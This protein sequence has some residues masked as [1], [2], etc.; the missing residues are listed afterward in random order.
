M[1]R[2][3]RLFA[4][5][6]ILTIILSRTSLMMLMSFRFFTASLSVGKSGRARGSL[7]QQ[8]L[9]RRGQNRGH[10]CTYWRGCHPRHLYN[11]HI[12]PNKDFH[13]HSKYIPEMYIWILMDYTR[14]IWMIGRTF[15]PPWGAPAVRGTPGQ[16][17]DWRGLTPRCCSSVTLE[18]TAA[19]R[20]T[21]RETWD[22]VMNWD[23]GRLIS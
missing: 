14:N 7:V 8:H 1:T 6:S 12:T 21:G 10:S 5:C 11:A 4:Y 13:V 18:Q 9:A 22:V 2:L 3:S 19:R 16:A 20:L 17:P 23:G 15:W